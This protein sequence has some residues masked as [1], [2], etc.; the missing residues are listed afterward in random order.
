MCGFAAIA[1]AVP[2]GRI[3]GQAVQPF[4][5]PI[6]ASCRAMPS[7]A[8]ISPAKPRLQ[9][10]QVGSHEGAQSFTEGGG[11]IQANVRVDY[12]NLRDRARGNACAAGY[13][14]GGKQLGYQFSLIW[15]PVDY[16]RFMA[17]MRAASI[18]AGPALR[19][20]IRHLRSCQPA[21]FSNDS[22]AAGTGRVLT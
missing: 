7:W 10:R 13:I 11:A 1:R 19:R 22:V 9:G 14:N 2:S 4:T 21:D 16:I 6:H 17:H 5:P 15:N 20:W 8:I 3:T 12:L 18:A